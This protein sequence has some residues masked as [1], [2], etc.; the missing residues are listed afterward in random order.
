MQNL[1]SILKRPTAPDLAYIYR[2]PQNDDKPL[3]MFLTG[4]ASDMMGTK[5][6][7]LDKICENLGLGYIRFD[8]R[9]HGQSMGLFEDGC[10]GLW[11]EDAL[12]IL[13]NLAKNKP[14]I[15]IGSSMGGWV[16]LL[17]AQRRKEKIYALI[18]LACAPDFTRDIKIAMTND[19]KEHF[20]THGFF[21]LPS[22]Y[23]GAPY[24]ITRQILD[25]G[26][27]YCVLDSPLKIFC[28]VR[29]IQGKKD[30]DVPWQTAQK[31]YDV[32]QSKDKKVIF[33]D[34]SDHRLSSPDDL[35]RLENTLHE[36]LNL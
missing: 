26:E 6:Q 19:Q 16:S 30:R 1:V 34:E 5:A 28:P 35:K 20:K 10:I 9:G 7:Y 27:Q 3:V 33:L 32:L 15:L 11:L 13:D 29:L 23:G 36:I 17:V 18:G 24:R 21:D 22:D 2:T 12:D 14:V 4:L 8:F 25:D 31:L